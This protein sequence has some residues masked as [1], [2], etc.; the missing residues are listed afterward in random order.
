VP[1]SDQR[2]LSIIIATLL[3][4]ILPFF[5]LY[6]LLSIHPSVSS[7]FLSMCSCSVTPREGHWN[8]LDSLPPSV[9]VAF[10][11]P[12]PLLFPQPDPLFP[13]RSDKPPFARYC[14]SYL[15]SLPFCSCLSFLPLW[16]HEKTTFH[17]CIAMC[18]GMD[19][20][21]CFPPA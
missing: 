14:W 3:C 13:S 1:S 16:S 21:A 20:S 8:F 18:K 15:F 11:S 6:L 9:L 4:V 17:R 2:I 5:F 19:V 12:F 7:L 10:P